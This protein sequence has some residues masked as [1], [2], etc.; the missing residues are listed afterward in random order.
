MSWKLVIS[1]ILSAFY[2]LYYDIM[3]PYILLSAIYSANVCLE[4]LRYA[5]SEYTCHFMSISQVIEH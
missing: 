2:E 1:D 3:V 5:N 4:V